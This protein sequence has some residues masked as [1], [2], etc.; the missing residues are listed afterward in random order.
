MPTELLIWYRRPVWQAALLFVFSFLLYANTLGHDFALDDAVVITDNRLVQRGLAGWPELFSHDTFYG[1]FGEEDRAALVA[2]GRYRPLTPALFALEAEVAAGPFLHHLLNVIWYG[3][4]TVVVFGLFRELFRDRELPWWL[5]WAAAA[6][7][8]A[9]PIHTEAVA[10]IKGRDEILVL[11]GAAGSTWVVLRLAR[12]GGAGQWAAAAGAGVLFFLGC[13]AKENAIT[14][15][16]VLPLLLYLRGRGGYRYLMP[17]GAAAVGYLALRFA[18]IGFDLGDPSPEL[19]NNPFLREVDG[20]LV[21]LSIVERLP[22]VLYT[23]LEYLR[24]LFFPVGLVHD[25]YP[26]AI[27]LKGWVDPLVWVSLLGHGLLLFWALRNLR[28]RHG[29]V[30]AGVLIYLITLSIVSNLLFSVG[31]FMS[32]RFLFMPSLGFVLAVAAGAGQIRFGRWALPVIVVVWSV[33]TIL[34]NPVWQ[35]NYTL[36]TSDL[37][38]QPRS[39]KLL[40]AAA[41]AKLDRYQALPEERRPAEAK[42]LRTAEEHLDRALEI[43]P[44][45][46]NAYL[47]RGNARLLGLRYDD[48]IADYHAARQWGVDDATVDQNL[49]IAL[50]RAGRA[51][52]EERNDLAAALAYLQQAEQ[53]DPRNYET[54]RLLGLAH[55]MSGRVEAAADY[56]QRALEIQPDNE[57]A[58]RNLEIARQQLAARPGSG[59]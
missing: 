19:M 8:A 41:G 27:E 31:T 5:V 47:L 49:V 26:A 42:L 43:H 33:L 36:F 12:R 16:A 50:Q 56:F 14:F 23:A 10:N 13:L 22:T 44:R 21:S 29:L 40:N 32:E 18:V 55:G 46:G 52:G 1:F 28:T 54:L 9:H 2:G 15:L 38:R 3:L 35:D 7:F 4:L 48:A 34:R 45:Y 51:A 17:V 11:L 58:R 6:L 20:R 30:A 57:G 39:A 24:L 53:L 37:S 59:E 25:Y